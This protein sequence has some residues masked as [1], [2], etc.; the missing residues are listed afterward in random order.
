MKTLLFTTLLILLSACATRRPAPTVRGTIQENMG[1]FKKCYSKYDDFASEGTPS[2]G[3]LALIFSLDEKGKVKK[4]GIEEG[5][6]VRSEVQECTI[7]TLVDLKFP[8]G[9]KSDYRINLKFSAQ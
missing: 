8:P 3:D 1:L 5:S 2:Q 4:A 7:D 6:E 9:T